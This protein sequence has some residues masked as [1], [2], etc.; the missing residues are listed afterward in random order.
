MAQC[1]LLRAVRCSGW[2]RIATLCRSEV[3]DPQLV[4]PLGQEQPVDPVQ[5]EWRLRVADGG[6]HEFAAAHALQA[7]ALDQPLH[8]AARNA[9]P[10]AIQLFP[11]L[12]GAV[13]AHIVLPDMLDVRR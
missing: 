10:L 11:D 2:T 1:P 12:V 5:R 7:Q 13:D 6:T 3:R 9:N 8:R 4:G